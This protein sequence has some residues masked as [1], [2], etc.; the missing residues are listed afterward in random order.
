MTYDTLPQPVAEDDGYQLHLA[1]IT[2]ITTNGIF[3]RAPTLA[4][5][6]ELGPCLSTVALDDLAADAQ[7]IVSTVNHGEQQV[8]LGVVQPT[9]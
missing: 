9:H 6:H 1:R 4:P 5:D 2:R 7:V 8:I 3:V